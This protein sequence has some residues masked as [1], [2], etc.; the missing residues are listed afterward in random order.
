M[1][2]CL[3]QTSD[4]EISCF[5][6]FFLVLR[7]WGAHSSKRHFY[8]AE[9]SSEKFIAKDDRVKKIID[10]VREVLRTSWYREE[11]RSNFCWSTKANVSAT[12]IV[13]SIEWRDEQDLLWLRYIR[14]WFCELIP[15]KNQSFDRH[16]LNWRRILFMN[17]SR[18]RSCRA[19]LTLDFGNWWLKYRTL[20][21]WV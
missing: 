12:S 1:R 6:M 16:Q 21:D 10:R 4:S 18:Y 5:R 14:S 3:K 17:C 11:V 13:C 8:S 15:V 7:L 20:C 2:S 19:A 9:N